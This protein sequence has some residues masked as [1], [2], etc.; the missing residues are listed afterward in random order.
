MEEEVG[1]YVCQGGAYIIKLPSKPIG[2]L[3]VPY[4]SQHI[5][6]FSE[7]SWFKKKMLKYFFGIT[8]EK[9]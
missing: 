7:I 5:S 3:N 4:I 8:Y 9:A 6:V 2:Y 1:T